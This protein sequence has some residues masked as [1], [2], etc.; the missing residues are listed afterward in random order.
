MYKNEHMGES[1]PPRHIHGALSGTA[2]GKNGN[3][4]NPLKVLV[5]ATYQLLRLKSHSYLK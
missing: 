2:I 4:L 3:A 5:T 1:R